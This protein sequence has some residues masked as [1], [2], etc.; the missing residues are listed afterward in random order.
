[1]ASGPVSQPS[2]SGNSDGKSYTFAFS[3]L[4]ILFFMWGF[5]TSLNDILIPHLKAVFDLSYTQASLI[6]F[7]FFSA[8]FIMS[9][10]SGK[11]IEY[12]GYKNGIVA[13]LATAGAGA[14]MFYPAAALPSYPVFLAGLFILA[15]GITI[16]QV[17]AN[18][19]VSVLGTPEGASSRLNL[20]QAFNS[21]GTTLA[22]A[23]GG[24]LILSATVL[25][26]DQLA[27]MSGDEL[28]A[29]KALKATTVQLPYI[30]LGITLFVLAGI[31]AFLKLPTISE[32]DERE[33]HHTFS[34]ALKV[35]HLLL[36]VVAIFVYVGAEVS[37][38]SYLVDF[39]KEPDIA[40][41]TEKA[42]ASLVSLYWGGAMIGR[43]LGSILMGEAAKSSKK[44]LYIIGVFLF[45]AI[46]GWSFTQDVMYTGVF[47]GFVILNYFMFM[48]GKGAPGKTLGILALAASVLSLTTI[49]F[50]GMTAV[51]LILSVGL[52]NSIMFPT[53]FTLAIKNLGRLTGKGSSLL[54]MAIV[55]GAI[56]PVMM[57]FL[58]DTIGLHKAFFL[59][60]ICYI[61]IAYYGFK[62]SEIK[63]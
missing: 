57:G 20:S 62:G 28:A 41:L 63:A 21:L 9:I 40:G 39:I 44:N 14:L 10:P 15:T 25:S 59:P 13:G 51:W 23:F 33:D 31:F 50:F 24:L 45:A 49:F 47:V 18:P 17:A 1:M 58:A 27:A 12:I 11:V 53:I 16:L 56:I 32:I 55:G 54:I 30:G 61:Y 60:S 36:G 38:G 48:V 7:T 43:F 19:Y 2:Q 4:T 26:I 5:L 6:Q 8:Y 35:R 22:P 42:A 37:I 3:A 46:I 29:Y 34:E 52:F